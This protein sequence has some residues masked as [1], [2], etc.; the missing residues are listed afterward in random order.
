[1]QS[2]TTKLIMT[3]LLMGIVV[4]SIMFIKLPIPLTQGYVHLGDGMILLAMLIL[5]WKYGAVAGGLGGALADVL[6]GYAVW[7]PW[8]LA[9]KAIMVIVA[10]LII[11]KLPIKSN[12]IMVFAMIMGGILMV[13]GYYVAEGVLYGNW[14]SPMI[15]VPWNVGQVIVGIALAMTVA[16]ALSNTS[17]RSQFEYPVIKNKRAADA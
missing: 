9:L 3:A 16:F 10:G 5:G 8:T 1:M 14:V 17:L 12:G 15:A 2:K 13:A 7:A 6:S 11:E 4:V